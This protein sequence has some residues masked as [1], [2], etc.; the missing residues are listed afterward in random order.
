MGS[1]NSNGRKQQRQKV[2]RRCRTLMHPQPQEV[3]EFIM[4]PLIAG[5]LLVGSTAP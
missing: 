5:I 1:S 3:A 4:A 2:L